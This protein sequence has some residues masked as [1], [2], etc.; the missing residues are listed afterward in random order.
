MKPHIYKIVVILAALM[1]LGTGVK[2]QT[3]TK[4]AVPFNFSVNNQTISAGDCLISRITDNGIV[5]LSMDKN[6]GS[7]IVLAQSSSKTTAD[8]HGK[9][10]FHRYGDTYFLA[11][12]STPNYALI[13][14]QSKTE[15]RLRKELSLA[16]A[17][18][19]HPSSQEPEVL[20]INVTNYV[21]N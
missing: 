16:S 9:W 10:Y 13:V 1:A 8:G 20:A 3:V 2:A 17:A 19:D 4:A 21:N 14:P 12:M 6:G 5:V 18:K 15:K 11:G 7:V